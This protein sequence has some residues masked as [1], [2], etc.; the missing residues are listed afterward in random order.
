MM[1]NVGEFAA[2]VLKDI[3][4]LKIIEEDDDK[5]IIN[6]VDKIEQG[7]QDLKCIGKEAQL[8]NQN[9]PE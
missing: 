2:V 4:N 9:Y 6:V 7:Y 3:S 8:A 1:N 5:G